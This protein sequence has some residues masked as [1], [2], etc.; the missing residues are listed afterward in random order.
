MGSVDDKAGSYGRWHHLTSVGGS[1]K[2]WRVP[3]KVWSGLTNPS[4][5]DQ[6]LVDL[7]NM[8]EVL[9]CGLASLD[10]ASQREFALHCVQEENWA[11]HKRKAVGDGEKAKK[12]SKNKAGTESDEL[13]VSSA[14]LNSK[15]T[16]EKVDKPPAKASSGFSLPNP[17]STS[18]VDS[19]FLKAYSFLIAGSFPELVTGSSNAKDAGVGDVKV[20]I[21]SFGGK[22]TTRFSKKTSEFA[23]M[24]SSTYTC[25]ILLS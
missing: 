14:A 3:K 6:T 4:D 8:E 18:T 21:E 22:V 1:C 9:L 11:G 7:L 5:I 17:E 23:F 25:A 10:G 15:E 19:T 24:L 16:D 20:L 12:K 2:G 13:V